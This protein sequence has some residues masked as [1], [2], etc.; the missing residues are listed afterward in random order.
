M[1]LRPVRGE[2]LWALGVVGGLREIRIWGYLRGIRG[3]R[4]LGLPRGTLDNF[5]PGTRQISLSGLRSQLSSILYSYEARRVRV[6]V[7]A[8]VRGCTKTLCT[9]ERIESTIYK[10]PEIFTVG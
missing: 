3:L 7:R 1:G 5:T 10:K 6:R 9:V 4:V 2:T 8:R